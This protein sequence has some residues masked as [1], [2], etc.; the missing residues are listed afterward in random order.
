LRLPEIIKPL[1]QRGIIQA[2]NRSCQQSGI[3]RTGSAD[4]QCADGVAGWHL[5]DR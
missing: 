5:H 4:R 2:K 3:D 1:C